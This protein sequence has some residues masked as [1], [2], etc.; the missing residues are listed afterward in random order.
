MKVTKKILEEQNLK[1]LNKIQELEKENAY[2]REG[3]DSLRR[4]SSGGMTA[5][6]VIAA[7]KVADAAAHVVADA[8]ILYIK[9]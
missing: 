3:F 5:S 8:R 2:I 4:L 1:Y 9:R 7:E 6:I